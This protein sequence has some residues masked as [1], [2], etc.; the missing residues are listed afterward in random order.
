MLFFSRFL[1]GG[2]ALA[3]LL[4]GGCASPLNSTPYGEWVQNDPASWALD[5]SAGH[6]LSHTLKITER[7]DHTPDV[8]LM[9][10]EAL[11]ALA[12]ERNPGLLAAER[13]VE[14]LRQRRDQVMSLDDPLLQ[15][16]SLGEMAQTASGRV[17]FMAG[18]SQR[19]PFPGKRDAQGNAADHMADAA[20]AQLA[21]KRLEVATEVR[22]AYWSHAYA[23][24]AIKVLDDDKTL[25]QRLRD[26]A[27]A[28]Y[29]AG[30]ASQADVLS[31]TVELAALEQQQLT[32]NQ[33]GH[34]A[35]ARLNDLLD[36]PTTAP[37][38]KPS[39]PKVAV[40]EATT[41]DLQHITPDTLLQQAAHHP[42]LT[43]LRNQI[44]VYRE[45]RRLAQLNR[46]P[47]LTVGL[48]YADVENRGD[49][50]VHNGDN[51]WW[52][53][54]GVHLPL[55]QEKRTA[56]EREA[57]AGIAE[58]TA[59]FTEQQNHLAFAITD[60]LA[61]VTAQQRAVILYETQMLP[62]AAQAIEAAASVYRAGQGDFVTLIDNSRRQTT[63]RL[64]H[65]AAQTELQKSWADLCEALG[66]SPS[67]LATSIATSLK[68]NIET[69]KETPQ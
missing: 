42:R 41:F 30:T 35:A 66:R 39:M 65:L 18:V 57:L 38:A 8:S 47:D 58:T 50:P 4:L 14:R 12:L 24:H 5:A 32:L 43:T 13:R 51:Q 31:A 28:R 1:I 34:T 20:Q 33:Q 52:L 2:L 23:R 17:G 37:W 16:A 26:A 54:L 27:A 55:W 40:F 60:A 68:T 64:M 6:H 22:R 46:Y 10:I 11:V 36:R 48:N 21:V 19:F 62:E 59:L 3:T 56:A 15:I 69:K 9:D 63:L 44:A 45:Q 53:S 49:S 7:P 25:R 61:R 29:R 67:D